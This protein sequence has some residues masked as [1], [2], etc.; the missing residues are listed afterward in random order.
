MNIKSL[1]YKC[2][3]AMLTFILSYGVHFQSFAQQD[4]LYTHFMFNKLVYNPG[5]A[6]SN[7]EFICATFLLHN[8]WT[9]FTGKG[10]TN[11][12]LAGDAPQTQ[13]FSIHGPVRRVLSGIGLYVV[14]DKLGFEN[15]IS[16]NAAMSVKKEFK[17]ATIQLGLNGGMMQ[18]TIKGEWKSPDGNPGGD[19]LIPTNGVE[20]K[21]MIPDL[22]VGLYAFTDRYY[23]GISAQHL[24]PGNF[25]LST[26]QVKLTRHFYILAGYNWIVPF[27][28]DFEVQPTV[29]IK[30][31][32]AKLQFDIN[33]NV[34]YKNK[35]WGGL[36]YREG[37]D[38]SLLLGMKLTPQLKFGYSY[39]MVTSRMSKY[40]SGT[41]EVMVNYCFKI[42]I[43]KEIDYPNIFWD[44]RHL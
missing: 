24:L 14:N 42:V 5:F 31:D 13:T 1:R 19:P 20:F 11:S 36:Q 32:I 18:K 17:F 16:I 35:F 4:A 27:N 44:T 30:K 38:F 29:L 12:N 43:R 9:G 6:G 37:G 21:D 26:A 2:C 28:P 7:K 40:Q 39:D 23:V 41:H 33:T 34:L 15:N 25:Q 3:L 8:Q 22:G 10:L